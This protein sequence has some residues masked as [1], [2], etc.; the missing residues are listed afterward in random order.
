MHTFTNYEE[1]FR[2]NIFALSWYR[3]RTSLASRGGTKAH[4]DR[5]PS[6]SSK[7]AHLN[8]SVAKLSRLKQLLARLRFVFLLAKNLTWM[9]VI[10]S[11]WQ[12]LIGVCA[13]QVILHL[14]NGLRFKKMSF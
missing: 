3:R 10:G 8:E 14:E 6:S 9:Q 12:L 4:F 11:F 5:T 7:I 13:D 2:P 1:G